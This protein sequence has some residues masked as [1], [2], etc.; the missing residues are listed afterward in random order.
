[1]NTSDWKLISET[2]PDCYDR[3][4]ALGYKHPDGRLQSNPVLVCGPSWIPNSP[5]SV[6]VMVFVLYPDGDSFWLNHKFEGG[7]T[8]TPTYWQEISLPESL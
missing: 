4:L 7:V 8:F 1:M 6:E 5:P 2:L 3:N